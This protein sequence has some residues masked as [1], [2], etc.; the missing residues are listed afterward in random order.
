MQNSIFIVFIFLLLGVSFGFI[1]GLPAGYII[2]QERTKEYLQTISK[3]NPCLKTGDELLNEQV[4]S[5]YIY[6][7]AS[8]NFT[9][10][11]LNLS[12][13]LLEG[14][15]QFLGEYGRNCNNNDFC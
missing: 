2:M 12:V 6:S 5:T 3:Y 11:F 10:N 13:E 14:Y 1:L 9:S 4:Y 7:K 15:E 8:D